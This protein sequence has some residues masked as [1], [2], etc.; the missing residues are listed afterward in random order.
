M[1]VIFCCPFV[2]THVCLLF[3][4]Q[5]TNCVAPLSI[6]VTSSHESQGPAQM[7]MSVKSS[8]G[9]GV[10]GGESAGVEKML[11][12]GVVCGECTGV[13]KMLDAGVVCGECTGVEKLLGDEC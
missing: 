2:N 13:E 5:H 8:A 9:G 12:A 10:V 6:L 7:T 11:D 1:T 3:S 4:K